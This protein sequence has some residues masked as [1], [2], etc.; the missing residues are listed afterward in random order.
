MAKHTDLDFGRILASA[1]EAAMGEESQHD[2]P[3]RRD[4][5]GGSHTMRRVATGIAVA[6]V[7]RVAVSKGPKLVTKAAPKLMNLPNLSDVSDR[8]SGMTDR[9]RDNLTER[10]WLG[11]E[12]DGYEED[13]PVDEEEDL[14]EDEEEDLPEDEEEDLPE[15]EEEDLPEDEEEDEPEAE[16]ED[17]PEDEEEDEPVD[18]FDDEDQEPEDEEEDLPED[19]EEDL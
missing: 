12:E 16:E 5:G 17:L 18:E 6:A 10:G 11:D 1:V 15:D 4:H 9:V 19:E 13:E 2:E 7:A 8:F 3:Q 14:P